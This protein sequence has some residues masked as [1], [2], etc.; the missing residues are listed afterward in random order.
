MNRDSIFKFLGI[1]CIGFS[2]L[3]FPENFLSAFIMFILTLLV[4]YYF[5]NIYHSKFMS[6]KIFLK[7]I[8][9]FNK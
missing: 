1:L 3:Y 8:L 9:L 6:K 7:E 2:S 4:F 5:D